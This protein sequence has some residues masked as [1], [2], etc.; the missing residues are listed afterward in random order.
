[1]IVTFAIGTD[2]DE[3]E[4]LVQNRVSAAI[5]SLPPE[6]Q[7]QGVTTKKQSTSIL[8]Y[9]RSCTSPDSRFDSLFLANYAV[10]NVVDE[11]RAFPALAM[12]RCSAPGNTPCAF[13]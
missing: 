4:I 1:M 10:I 13:G 6:V 7:L 3:D 2:P 9:R 5:S 8:E 12:C 11:L